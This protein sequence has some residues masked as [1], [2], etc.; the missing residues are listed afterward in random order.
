MWNW[1]KHRGSGEHNFSKEAHLWPNGAS[2][3]A[4]VCLTQ[5]C[6]RTVPCLNCSTWISNSHSSKLFLFSLFFQGCLFSP[7]MELI[8]LTALCLFFSLILDLLTRDF[9]CH[10]KCQDSILMYS[11]LRGTSLRHT[12]QWE[13][14]RG[15][16]EIQ[17]QWESAVRL[18][19]GT[20]SVQSARSWMGH[21][22]FFA[23]NW[24]TLAEI[25]QL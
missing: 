25:Q 20:C 6:K 11:L 5:V 12:A 21:H 14:D 13:D 22:S 1:V 24:W 19:L 17:T 16:R 4:C 15:M 8:I 3:K 2:F 23:R 9:K 18:Q 10:T 7:V